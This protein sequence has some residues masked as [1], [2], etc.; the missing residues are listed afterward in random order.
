MFKSL[1]LSYLY[2]HPVYWKLYFGPPFGAPMIAVMFYLNGSPESH[3]SYVFWYIIT[4]CVLRIK[5]CFA[6]KEM[7]W[8]VLYFIIMEYDD[9]TKHFMTAWLIDILKMQRN[10]FTR[11]SIYYFQAGILNK[12][13]HDGFSQKWTH[14]L[15]D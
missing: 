13:L 5:K 2:A 7:F 15:N 8:S 9:F 1:C 10:S 14:S 12:C 11:W 6:N 3:L 4:L